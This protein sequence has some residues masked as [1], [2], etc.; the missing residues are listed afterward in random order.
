MSAD[1][2]ILDVLAY[3]FAGD[4]PCDTER[5]IRR[6]LR[7]HRLG[8]YQQERVDLLRRFKAEVQSEIQQ[9][10]RSCY[11]VG[12]D[13]PY[14]AMEDFDVQR[15]IKELAASYPNISPEQI[16]AFVHFAVYLYYLR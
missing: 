10:H 11:F 6:R 4:A 14:A 13:G 9:G 16:A 5:K 8:P 7:Y 15:M 3:E 1:A 12:S 2:V